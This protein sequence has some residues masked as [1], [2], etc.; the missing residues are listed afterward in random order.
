MVKDW[1][2]V[3]FLFGR[4]TNPFPLLI[5]SLLR[6]Q[7]RWIVAI[8]LIMII[9]WSDIV[10]ICNKRE[11]DHTRVLVNYIVM[12]WK[13][14]RRYLIMHNTRKLCISIIYYCITTAKCFRSD[15]SYTSVHVNIV[16]EK[17]DDN[18]SM[19]SY[20]LL[21]IIAICL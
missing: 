11:R 7:I 18:T 16:T 6:Y 20:I 13:S 2:Y 1:C 9:C 12:S 8:F 21:F 15:L 10:I 17:V 19:L 3:D 5:I 4:V 14:N